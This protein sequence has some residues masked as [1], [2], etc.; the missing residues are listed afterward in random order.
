MSNDLVNVVWKISLPPNQKL[1]L[2]RYAD[3][4]DENGREIYFSIDT[5]MAET[6]LSRSTVFRVNDKLEKSALMSRDLNASPSR[7][8]A[9]WML[10]VKVL[11]ERADQSIRLRKA[12]ALAKAQQKL[13]RRRTSRDALE[14]K[15]Q[16]VAMQQK[17]EE[18]EERDLVVGDIEKATES[19]Y[20][21]EGARETQIEVCSPEIGESTVETDQCPP[22]ID[23]CPGET[24]ESH[25]DT[26]YIPYSS[27]RH[28]SIHAPSHSDD[29]AI[30]KAFDDA[31]QAAWGYPRPRR[32]RNDL[33]IGARWKVLGA[34]PEAVARIAAETFAWMIDNSY[35]AP[36]SL[37]AIDLR[38]RTQIEKGQ[39][40]DEAAK[41]TH[42]SEQIT[43]TILLSAWGK[44]GSWHLFMGAEPEPP[45]WRMNYRVPLELKS[46]FLES[47]E[48]RKR[49][50]AERSK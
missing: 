2:V 14:A 4:A 40:L 27:F 29:L 41:K 12:A 50:C 3:R 1:V 45:D 31:F 9:T 43:W 15:K 26:Q 23:Q 48:S 42:Q 20:A 16:N 7:T 8:T 38:V 6:G 36:G 37:A 11:N 47:V 10:N 34:A 46:L 39:A 5:V 28:P 19:D 44:G 32:A 25:G 13:Q 24:D 49:W 21:Q 30:V 22:E 17:F 33:E 35:E 18:P